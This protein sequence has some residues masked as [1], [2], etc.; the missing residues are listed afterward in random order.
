MLPNQGYFFLYN[1]LNTTTTK[2]G[3]IALKGN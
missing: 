2:R 3:G 1:Q